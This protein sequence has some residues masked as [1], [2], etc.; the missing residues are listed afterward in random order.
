MSIKSSERKIWPNIFVSKF[1]V[2]CLLFVHLSS[3]KLVWKI[4]CILKKFLS[5]YIV[6]CT[7]Y[8]VK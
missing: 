8:F 6:Q 2:L 1:F 4:I 5:T 7:P 3:Y